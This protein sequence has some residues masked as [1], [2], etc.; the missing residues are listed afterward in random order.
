MNCRLKKLAIALRNMN[1]EEESDDVEQMIQDYYGEWISSLPVVSKELQEAFNAKGSMEDLIMERWTN[2]NW[3][4]SGMFRVAL[5]AQGDESFIIKIAKDDL[6][7]KMNESEFKRQLEFGGLFPKVHHHGGVEYGSA[8]GFD[9]IVIDRV[10]PI[11]N[12]EELAG[13]FPELEEAVNVIGASNYSPGLFSRVFSVFLDFE[14]TNEENKDYADSLIGTSLYW[15]G[16]VGISDVRKM[17]LILNELRRN[18]LFNRIAALSAKLDLLAGDFGIG[19]FGVTSD[20]E[21]VI[22]DSSFNEDF[23]V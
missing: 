5:S 17:D 9:W 21:L 1:L 19:N 3:I 20:G 23:R 16:Q 18:P 2:L 15:L 11:R 14:K 13:V 12:D 7:A 4:G 10:E 22:I 6:G 8:N